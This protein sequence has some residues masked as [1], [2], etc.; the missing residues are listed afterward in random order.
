MPSEAKRIEQL[1]QDVL[2]AQQALDIALRM[3]L[4]AQ[5]KA[6]AEQLIAA[7]H[8]QESNG[9]QSGSEAVGT[10][11]QQIEGFRRKWVYLSGQDGDGEI[12]F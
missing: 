10:A 3:E 6:A 1:R 4:S 2:T 9:F 12:P 5:I 11:L 7:I 8:E